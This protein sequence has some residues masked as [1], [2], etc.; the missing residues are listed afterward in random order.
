M[1]DQT[2]AAQPAARPASLWRNRNFLLLWGGRAVSE[3]GN[4]LTN[5][6]FPALFLALTGSASQAGLLSA[7]RLL[8]YLLLGLIAGALVDRWNR[9]RVMLVC[10]LLAFVVVGA[11]PI[12]LG[13]NALSLPLLALLVFLEG[14]LAL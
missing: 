13:Q 5:L 8:P 12:L 3:L 1:S 6:A 10:D 9:R 11:V 2:F 7:A 4:E 14:A